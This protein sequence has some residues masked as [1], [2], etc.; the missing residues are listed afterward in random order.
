MKKLLNISLFLSLVLG[1]TS[2]LKDKNII[3]PD[4]PGAIRNIVEFKNPAVPSS[5]TSDVMPFYVLSYDIQPS[6]DMN[7]TVSY[8]GADPAPNDITVKVALDDDA[9]ETANDEQDMNMI[10]LPTSMYSIPSLNVTIPKG[11]RTGTIKVT[12][13][14]DQFDLTKAYALG[15]KITGVDGT[16]APVSGNF[17]TIV[18]SVG[19]KNEFDGRYDV[20]GSCVDA[21]GLYKGFYPTSV[22]LISAGANSVVYYN[23]DFDYPNYIVISLSTGGAANTGIRPKITIDQSSGAVTAIT[24]LASGADIRV[25]GQY[26]KATKEMDIEWKSGRWSVKEHYK[27]SGPR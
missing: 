23:H 16:S 8:S 6:V 3:G 7:I 13:K 10:P 2:C 17:G 15:F 4:A 18:V 20:T 21:N 11:Q 27:Y 25:S 22:D 1:L 5:S 26:N 9:I 12:L 19:A 24:N 14:T